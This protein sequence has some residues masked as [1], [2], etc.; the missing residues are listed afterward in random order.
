LGEKATSESTLSPRMGSG[1]KETPRF[2]DPRKTCCHADRQKQKPR[3]HI[4]CRATCYTFPSHH[5]HH[6]HCHCQM[7]ILMCIPT[8]EMKL[9]IES[10]DLCIEITMIAPTRS[11]SKV[12]FASTRLPLTLT[13]LQLDSRSSPN[14]LPFLSTPICISIASH[15]NF[16]KH[17]ILTPFFLRLRRCICICLCH[18]CLYTKYPGEICILGFTYLPIYLVCH[19]TLIFDKRS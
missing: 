15:T 9:I 7:T 5:N 19:Q 2:V 13:H 14:R 11:C 6:H 8:S 3:Y 10:H 18:L 4:V 17:L 16:T 1:N 12:P